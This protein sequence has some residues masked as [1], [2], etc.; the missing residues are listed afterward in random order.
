[1]TDEDDAP[2]S[3]PGCLAGLA[4]CLASAAVT[5]WLG[6][7]AWQ[8]IRDQSPGVLIGVAAILVA[9]VAFHALRRHWWEDDADV[10]SQ[11]WMSR[12]QP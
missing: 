12:Q 3:R 2:P 7:L 11:A 6:W 5:C 1:M 4:A 10:M 9:A 8:A